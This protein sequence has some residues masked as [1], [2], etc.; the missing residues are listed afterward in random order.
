MRRDCCSLLRT[1]DLRGTQM[2]RLGGHKKGEGHSLQV[3]RQTPTLLLS[4]TSLIIPAKCAKSEPMILP[5][6]ACKIDINTPPA[7]PKRCVWHTMFSRTVMTE[8]VAL[9]ARLIHWAMRE[10]ESRVVVAPTVE[11]GLH[12]YHNSPHEH[13]SQIERKTHTGN[14]KP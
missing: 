7:Y 10:I 9:C 13:I 5:A 8:L 4:S 1:Y 12:H 3:S 2:I 14:Y 6:P 11:P